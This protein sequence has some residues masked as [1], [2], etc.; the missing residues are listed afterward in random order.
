MGVNVRRGHFFC[1][2]GF[3]MTMIMRKFFEIAVAAFL[4]A[5]AMK[6]VYAGSR[7]DANYFTNTPLV[8]HEG[9]T[10]R[11]FDD[12]LKDKIV[13]INFIYT[14]C[15][16]ACPLETAQ[17]VR[18][19]KILGDKL[20]KEI[21]FY[22]ISI[23]PGNDTPEMLKEYKEKF[24]ARWTFLTGD[25]SDIDMLRRKLGLYVDE[26]QDGSNN[27]N[28]SMIIGNQAT[29][30]W[31]KRSPFENP[32]VL[33][34]QLGHWLTGWKE[35][36]KANDYAEAPKLR[37]LSRGEEIFRTRCVSCHSID[38]QEAEDALGP[39]L[40]A[41]TQRRDRQWL[42]DWLKAPDNMLKNKD[43]IAVSL[44][45]QYNKL[46]M[47]NL[48]LTQ[49]DAFALLKYFDD[50]MQRIQLKTNQVDAENMSETSVSSVRNSV[51]RK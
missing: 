36:K 46:A 33:A 2:K 4:M 7:W 10:V 16:E 13:A 24:K 47:P 49:E 17:L 8:T 29:G 35:A 3:V 21:H 44:F 40:F 38:G 5:G 11:F 15:A 48:R 28:V 37:K 20:G 19:Q 51:S 43:P 18:V 39:D 32:H 27:H 26:I 41:V 22:S 25:K 45:K 34:D 30:Q 9:R 31:M 14:H 12:L 23:D 6:A 50:E 1:F 42:L